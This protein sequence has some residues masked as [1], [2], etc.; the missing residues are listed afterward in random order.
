MSAFQAIVFDMDGLLINSEPIYQASWSEGVAHF[1]Y[2]LSQDINRSMLGL[3]NADSEAVLI[4]EF[5][6]SFPME[7]FRAQWP[8]R[9]KVIAER[10][11]LHPMPGALALLDC[12][13]QKGIPTAIAT[14]T[15]RSKAE[16]CL[17]RAGIQ[18]E[19]RAM[20]CGPE[21]ANGK[22]A[23]DIYLAVASQLQVKPQACIA[24]EDS[25]N[26]MRSA[27]DAGMTAIMVPDLKAAEDD[28]AA[29]ADYILDDLDAA[30]AVLE[31]LLELSCA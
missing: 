18:H 9:W 26:G 31:N 16:R 13:R 7:A 20:V 27:I 10:E 30:A 4:R 23:P 29:R 8:E 24:L 25:N 15:A 19:F 21:V 28:V 11:G 14:S 2:H 12:M 5:G 6:E 1:G 3:S 17:E 22:P